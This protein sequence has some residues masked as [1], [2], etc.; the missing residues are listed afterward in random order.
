MLPMI[1]KTQ[2]YKSVSKKKDRHRI[3]KKSCLGSDNKK[4]FC[5]TFQFDT[6]LKYCVV[7]SFSNYSQ[8][9]SQVAKKKIV[10]R[11]KFQQV[12]K[13]LNFR[14][15]RKIINPTSSVKYSRGL[16]NTHTHM[17]HLSA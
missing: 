16:F 17:E 9:V 15:S 6:D 10:F 13:N 11:N 1:S 5:Y 3:P 7:S 8:V 2:S 12:N 4:L 14:V